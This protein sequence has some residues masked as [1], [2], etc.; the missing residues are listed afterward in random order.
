MWSRLDRASCKESEFVLDFGLSVNHGLRR[1]LKSGQLVHVPVW[2]L[3][4][5]NALGVAVLMDFFS[6][7]NTFRLVWEL[8]HGGRDFRNLLAEIQNRWLRD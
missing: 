5:S 8:L 2:A 1:W 7:H 6:V 4:A 3:Q